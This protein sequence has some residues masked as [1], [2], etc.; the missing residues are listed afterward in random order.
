MRQDAQGARQ[1]VPLPATPAAAALL[2]AREHCGARGPCYRGRAPSPCSSPPVL[3][4]QAEAQLP[5]PAL[6]GLRGQSG[7]GAHGPGPP[8]HTPGD[9]HGASSGPAGTSSVLCREVSISRENVLTSCYAL[10]VRV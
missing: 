10:S 7:D 4:R 6:R 8:L 5:R 1:E 2:A 9:A 3:T